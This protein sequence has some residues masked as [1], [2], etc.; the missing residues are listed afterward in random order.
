MVRMD[1]T[2]YAERL[3]G[4]LAQSAAAGDEHIREAAERLTRALDPALRLSLM[5]VLSEAA[6]EITSAMP[7]GSVE[8]RL[9]GRDIEFVVDHA[10]APAVTEAAP[11]VEDEADEGNLAR[12]TLRL[13]ES[14]KVRAEELA[15]KHGHSLNTWIVNT[16]RAATRENA[17]NID[18]DLSSIPFLDRDFPFNKSSGPRRMSGWV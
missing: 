11:T 18:I 14:I 9:H 6:A 7:S 4:E 2:T 10:P 12:I 17:V 5:E 1:I 13:P 3:R 16:L 8:A 15:A